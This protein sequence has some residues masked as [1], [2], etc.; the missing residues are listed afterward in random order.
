[1]HDAV[2]GAAEKVGRTTQPVQHAAAHDAGTV[3]VRV[4]VHFH[5]RVHPN[6]TQSADNLG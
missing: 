4:Y 1:V 6:D 3:C 5:G 2:L